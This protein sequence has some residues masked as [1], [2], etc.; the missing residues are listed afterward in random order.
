MNKN[1]Y[2][3]KKII[4]VPNSVKHNIIHMISKINSNNLSVLK[5][6]NNNNTNTLTKQLVIQYYV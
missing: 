1:H 3:H 4:N 5:N 6:V 2:L